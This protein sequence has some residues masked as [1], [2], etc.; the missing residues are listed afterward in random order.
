LGDLPNCLTVG[1]FAKL[2]YS[3]AICQIALQLGDLPN[4]LTVEQFAKLPYKQIA[5]QNAL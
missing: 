4:C 2:P 1:Q 5:L 3:W